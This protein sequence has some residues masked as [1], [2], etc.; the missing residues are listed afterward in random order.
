MFLSLKEAKSLR[1]HRCA[2]VCAL[3]PLAMFKR[4][5]ILGIAGFSLLSSGAARSQTTVVIDDFEKGVGAWTRNDKVKSDNPAAGV[6]LVDIASTA[7]G[8]NELPNSKGAGLFAFKAANKSWASASIRVRGAE[9]SKAGAQRL[10]FWIN[11]GGNKPGVE[12][13]LRGR[14]PLGGGKFRDEVYELPMP[15]RL[16]SP[17]W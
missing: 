9:W 4:L 13:V 12:L 14:V 8:P 1:V 2:V 7:P 10:T 15:I 11:A 5:T 16:D 3:T 17:N 6:L